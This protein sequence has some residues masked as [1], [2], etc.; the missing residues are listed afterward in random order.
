MEIVEIIVGL[1]L[2]IYA[3]LEGKNWKLLNTKKRTMVVAAC[4]FAV[5]CGWN[6]YQK[7][8]KDQVI[9]KINA[10]FG[11][12]NDV[13]G[14][15]IPS[16][17]FGF[18]DPAATFT[19]PPKTI[20]VFKLFGEN[21]FSYYVKDGKL[22]IN[23]VVRDTTGK[24]IL[25]IYDNSWTVYNN[26]FEYNYDDHG[27]EIVTAGDRK[28]YFHLDFRDTAVYMEGAILFASDDSN[29][30]AGKKGIYIFN[31]DKKWA[32]VAIID[33]LVLVDYSRAKPMFKYPRQK[34]MGVR[35]T[36]ASN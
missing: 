6:A 13:P 35:A 2:G 15:T 28:V 11:E 31:S 23:V 20:G 4:I 24:P 17:K 9:E 5:I 33:H 18:E 27:I 30:R 10:S 34:Y 12:L 26:D 19:A 8:A 22:T 16:I 36:L 21:L 14:A 1:I 3:A 25:A 32:A 29:R 7:W